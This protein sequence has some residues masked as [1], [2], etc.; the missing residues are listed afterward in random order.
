MDAVI[1]CAGEGKRLR[2]LTNEKPKPMVNVNGRPLMENSLEYAAQ[3]DVNHLHIVVGYMKNRI[4]EHYG[5]SYN[6]I[7][8][9]YYEQKERE[10]LA[11]ALR[12]VKYEFEENFLLLLSDGVYEN[13]PSDKIKEDKI[14]LV[15]EKVPIEKAQEY[16]VCVIDDNEKV[17]SLVEK[18]DSPPSSQ[19]LCGNYILPPA[20]IDYCHSVEP[21]NTGE[22]GITDAIN[23]LLRSDK[24]RAEIVELELWRVDVARP[25]DIEDIERREL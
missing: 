8:I 5:D 17:L 20:I 14:T 24:R 19:I 25:E 6:G 21:S 22:Y 1:L 16:G 2:P 15:T 3:M 9:S 7:E 13:F 11:H 10:G 23:E 12:Q 18:P 4:M